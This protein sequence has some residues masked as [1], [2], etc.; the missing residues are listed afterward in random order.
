MRADGTL[1]GWGYNFNGRVGDGTTTQR[2]SPVPVGTGTNWMSVAA[3]GS[4]TAGEQACRDLWTWGHNFYGQLGDGTTTDKLSPVQVYNPGPGALLFSPASATAG[5]SVTVTGT[6]LLGLTALSVNGVSVPLANISNNTATGFTF[7]VPA[8]T[9]ATGILTVSVGC[10][11]VSST[12]FTVLATA[13]GKAAAGA[14]LA[15]YPNPA[16]GGAATLTGAAPGTAVT[17]LD[18][19]G[20]LVTSAAADA[21]GKATLALPASRPT[22]VYVVRA[23][24]HVL[25]L[26][27]E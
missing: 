13:R 18:A 5:T 4:Y 27:V 9:M 26:V 11:T 10:G 1:W 2:L 14:G 21:A 24:P 17:V 7:V 3:G 16:P 22:G 25:R 15:L 12:A 19:L 20:R 6:G 23:G 8:G